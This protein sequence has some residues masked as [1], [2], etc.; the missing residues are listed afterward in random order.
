[1]QVEDGEAFM[2]DVPAMDEMQAEQADQGIAPDQAE[3]DHQ[4]VE[5]ALKYT[6]QQ[7]AA[8]AKELGALV[9]PTTTKSIY[10]TVDVTDQT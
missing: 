2:A 6:D 3:M 8:I 7:I 10:Q 5:A 9:P 4:D 1:M